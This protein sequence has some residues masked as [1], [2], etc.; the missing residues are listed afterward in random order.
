[1]RR[2][3]WLHPHLSF[4]AFSAIL[5]VAFAVSLPVAS[6]AATLTVRSDGTGDVPTIQAGLD[7][8]IRNPSGSSGADTLVVEPGRYGEDLVTS[9]DSGRPVTMICPGGPDS[10]RV[11]S[12]DFRGGVFAIS[13]L[14]VGDRSDLLSPALMEQCRFLGAANVSNDG[15]SS[16]ELRD[17]SFL[18]DANFLAMWGIRVAGCQ[19]RD[20]RVSAIAGDDGLSFID[21]LFAGSRTHVDARGRY[22]VEFDRCSFRGAEGLK[23]H[24]LGTT[25][26]EV[27][28]RR[29]LFLD[30][31]GAA[32]SSDS[33]S[34]HIGFLMMDT[35]IDRCRGGVRLHTRTSLRPILVRDT[36][37]NIA[38]SGVDLKA[39]LIIHGSGLIPFEDVVI[40]KCDGEGVRLDGVGSIFNVSGC[41]FADNGGNGLSFLP[42]AL[43]ETGNLSIR[44][45]IIARNG[46]AG[47]RLDVG[48]EHG[49]DV[50]A[51]NTVVLNRADGILVASARTTANLQI[52]NNILGG[53]GGAGIRVAVPYVGTIQRNDSWMNQ[54]P[55][56]EGVHDE[57]NLIEDPRFCDPLA[58][59]FQVASSSP[60]APSGP[61]EQIGSLGVGCDASTVAIDV[62]PGSSNN[63]VHSDGWLPVA[64]LSHRM[65]DARQVDPASVRLEGASAAERSRFRDVNEDGLLDFVARF[66]KRDLNLAPGDQEVTL[67]ARTL[68][69][70]PIRGTDRITTRNGRLAATASASSLEGLALAVANPLFLRGTLQVTVTV[71]QGGPAALRL[72]DISG[73]IVATRDWDASLGAQTVT[74]APQGLRPGVYWLRLAHSGQS[75]TKEVRLLR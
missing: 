35:R 64:I 67:E 52:E 1:V 33:T 58:G 27:E 12:V 68:Y 3:P 34:G 7:S 26:T 23:I 62:R 61:Y 8:L 32:V 56:Y 37:E 13:G 43:S 51:R 53:N 45:S 42:S 2:Q 11:R 16:S 71:P 31:S 39:A 6:K 69:G 60:C 55:A 49:A 25:P 14:Q 21:C 30:I 41:S 5:L 18:A 66:R 63:K 54:G 57:P 47:L 74:L 22:G 40:R 4:A 24:S 38:G 59:D 28:L 70:A 20:S 44:E 48:G 29:C 19:F 75:V 72:L 17:C 73:R 9:R 15:F 36:V 10:T 50:L 65:F 46:G